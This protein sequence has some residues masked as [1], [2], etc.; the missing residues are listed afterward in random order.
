MGPFFAR[1]EFLSLYTQN[2]KQH[3]RCSCRSGTHGGSCRSKVVAVRLQCSHKA[4]ACNWV[5]GARP[6]CGSACKCKVLSLC[7]HIP[8]TLNTNLQPPAAQSQSTPHAV[9][10]WCHSEMGWWWGSILINVL[11]IFFFN[12]DLTIEFMFLCPLSI[13][14]SGPKVHN[15]FWVSPFYL[16]FIQI[17]LTLR[18]GMY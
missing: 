7:S 4:A 9:Y 11:L 8:P 16:V 3:V 12:K 5:V 10:C 13:C 14:P 18:A 15:G 1:L 6:R 17:L 2:I